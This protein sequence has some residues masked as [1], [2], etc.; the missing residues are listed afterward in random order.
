MT[1]LVL[2]ALIAYFGLTLLGLS[3]LAQQLSGREREALSEL[4]FEQTQCDAYFVMTSQCMA[5]SN[6]PKVAAKYKT[7]A[8]ARS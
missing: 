8:D 5:N 3:A 1:R 7:A 2:R 4:S 6:A